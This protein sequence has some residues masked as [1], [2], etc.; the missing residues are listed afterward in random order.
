MLEAA[1][2]RFGAQLEIRWHA[3]E[4]RPA[5]APLPDPDGDYISEHWEQRVL[6]MAKERGLVMRVPRRQIRSRSA[7]QAAL[8]AQEQG[9]FADLDRRLFR[10]RFELDLDISDL[11]VLRSLGA[12]AG[13]EPEA[14]AYAVKT[15]AFASQL[16]DDLALGQAIGLR[17]VPAALVGPAN[18]D[19][20]AFVVDAEPVLG[21][22]PED[23]MLDAIDRA[24]RGD[25]THA[26]MRFRPDIRI[27]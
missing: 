2:R 1:S 20:A 27:K 22:V 14:L 15:N 4:L 26:R 5:P 7:L 17:G 3:F 19:L 18:D 12:E 13:L 6:P 9:R 16:D 11:D 24:I 25:R 10:A 23:W 21:A 8:F